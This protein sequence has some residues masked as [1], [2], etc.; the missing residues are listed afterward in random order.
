MKNK[1]IMSYLHRVIWRNEYVYMVA[2]GDGTDEHFET[3]Y[4]AMEWIEK[5]AEKKAKKQKKD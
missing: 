2:K 5:E 1:R 4:E 3:I